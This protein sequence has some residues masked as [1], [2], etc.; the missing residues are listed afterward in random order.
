MK[1]LRPREATAVSFA[2]RMRDLESRFAAAA[3]V[4]GDVYL[5]NFTPCAPVDAILIA[6]EPSLGWWAR[7]PAEA[8]LRIAAG[9][10]NFMW[11]PEDF[12]LHYAA[13]RS[14]C[15]P[16]GAYHITD[17]SKGAMTVAKAHVDRDARYARWVGLL[18]E[19][20]ELIA[21]PHARIVA[22]GREVRILLDRHGFDRDVTAVMHYSAQASRYRDSALEGREPEF[23]VFARTLSMEDIVA[24]ADAVMR[25]HAVP[26]TLSSETITRLRKA[27]LSDSRKKLAF[28]YLT[29]FTELR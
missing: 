3:A 17:V 2:D 10:R 1:A 21:K 29:A 20:V 13:R 15:P 18:H 11:S 19:E 8:A 14:L 26:A 9:F 5:P 4:D 25:E 12:I 27:K 16:G 22:I 23:E 7:T 6:M 24:T 28:V